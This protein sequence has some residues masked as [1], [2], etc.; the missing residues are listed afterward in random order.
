[1]TFNL[2]A[3]VIFIRQILLLVKL[4]VELREGIIVKLRILKVLYDF[5]Y[6]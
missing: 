3:F 6:V 2:I 1:M 4:F 5:F